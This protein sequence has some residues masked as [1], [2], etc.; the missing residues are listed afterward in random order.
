[1]TTASIHSS[2]GQLMLQLG[3]SGSF[4]Q[5][6][7]ASGAATKQLLKVPVAPLGEWVH[8]EYGKV[9]FS[10]KDFDDMI[11]NSRTK[12]TGYE[13]P[14]FLGHPKDTDTIEG[15]P[16]YAFLSDVV[17]EGDFLYGLYEPI[18]EDTFEQMASGGVKVKGVGVFRYSSAEVLKNAVSKTDGESIGTLLVGTALTNRPFI[19]S[20][21]KPELVSRFTFADQN[22]TL[23]ILFT[24]QMTT[25]EA[26][27]TPA[28]V[29]QAATPV[30]AQTDALLDQLT[31]LADTITQQN[32]QIVKLTE[33]L[34]AATSRIQEL[35]STSLKA[36]INSMNVPAVVKETFSDLILSSEGE[37]RTKLLGTLQR[38]SEQNAASIT[39]ISG[40]VNQTVDSASAPS[41]KEE[42]GAQPP[43]NPYEAIIQRNIAL[44]DKQRAMSV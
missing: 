16:A 31:K 7:Q 19:P 21:P 25:T 37:G 15:A 28:T 27:S 8:S 42:T 13:P 5:V 34:T 10:Q 41:T 18:E 17:Q 6:V 20:L 40:D 14:L 1:M 23:A 9:V 39:G 4:A 44:S 30:V 24:D 3:D 35:E 26:Q 32:G 43:V 22:E 36:T 11:H 29:S 12:K 33:Q 2:S 38:L